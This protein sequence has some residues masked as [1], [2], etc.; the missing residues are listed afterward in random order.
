MVEREISMSESAPNYIF[1][2]LE[3]LQETK[4]TSRWFGI[5][6]KDHEIKCEIVDLFARSQM[7]EGKTSEEIAKSLFVTTLDFDFD[8]C[9]WLVESDHEA[10][11]GA[12]DK[13][14]RY[15]L[16]MRAGREATKLDE[17]IKAFEAGLV[18]TLHTHINYSPH[19]IENMIENRTDYL[20]L[21]DRLYEEESDGYRFVFSTKI[22]Q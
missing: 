2:P 7:N 17:V 5:K 8:Q 15:G 22:Q 10:I 13:Y 6:D 21:Q 12:D 3:A 20:M 14:I 9:A 16:W 11:R 18:A 1:T 4:E 19:I